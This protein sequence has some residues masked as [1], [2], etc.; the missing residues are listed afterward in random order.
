M[1]NLLKNKYTPYVVAGIAVIATFILT[2]KKYS[3]SFSEMSKEDV[4]SAHGN[5]EKAFNKLG[6]MSGYTTPEFVATH[7]KNDLISEVSDMLF[8]TPVLMDYQPIP[9]V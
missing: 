9:S 4:T 2:K 8:A 6:M 3:N 5:L 1:E 7:S